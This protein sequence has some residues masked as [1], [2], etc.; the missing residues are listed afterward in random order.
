MGVQNLIGDGGG[1][2]EEHCSNGHG[3]AEG[4][5]DHGGLVHKGVVPGSGPGG[6]QEVL[7]ALR[8]PIFVQEEVGQGGQTD[9]NE[10]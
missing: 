4:A 3:Q 9:P 5:D 10:H 1:G 8:P 2:Q 7:L 6:R